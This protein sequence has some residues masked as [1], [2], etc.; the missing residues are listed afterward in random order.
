MKTD[1]SEL[2]KKICQ[3]DDTKA[4]ERLYYTL[5]SKLLKFCMYYTHQQEPAEDIVSELFVTCWN[6]RKSLAHITYPE[7]YLFI[8]TKNQA[9]KYRKKYSTIHLVEI[10][11]D[12][13]QLID[14]ADPSQKLERK[15][16]HHRLD[17]AIETLP[18][19]ARMVFR[20]I[21]ENGLKYK[22]VAEILE[23]SP[24][25]V[26]TQLFRAIAKLRVLLKGYHQSASRSNA[27]QCVT[28]GFM[29]IN[30][31]HYFFVTCRH[32]C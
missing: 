6:N 30:V 31:L 1:I 4:F 15:E 27:Q 10:E 32:F 14:I 3:D 25:T 5:F 8:A 18:L 29:L 28:A 9:L 12:Q 19:Q 7:T 20:L 2:W 16:L 17:Q 11:P 26:Q 23:I 13:H 22:E 21:K 24:R